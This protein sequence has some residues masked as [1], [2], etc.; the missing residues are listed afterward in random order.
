MAKDLILAVIGDIGCDGATYRA[1]EFDGDG[2]FALN[3]EERMTLCNM[4]IEAGGKNGVIAPDQVTSASSQN[5]RFP[6]SPTS[7]S[8]LPPPPPPRPQHPQHPAAT[9]TPTKAQTRDGGG[10]HKK[11]TRPPPPPRG[12]KIFWRLIPTL[13]RQRPRSP[14]ASRRPSWTVKPSW[15]S[16]KRPGQ[17]SLR[18]LLRR[19]PGRA[20]G[21]LRPP[22]QERGVHFDD[23][24][25]FSR[26]DGIKNRAS[27]PGLAV[28]RRRVCRDRRNHRS[29]RVLVSE[30]GR[31]HKVAL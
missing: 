17:S 31:A 6:P 29:A 13:S 23:Q 20:V 3:I 9:P 19:L 1:M 24:P 16:F 7:P 15:R 25:Q 14:A 27:L 18:G 8:P 28:H 26:T 4:V 22:E 11:K 5:Q 12:K 30:M 10:P 21:Y 2:V